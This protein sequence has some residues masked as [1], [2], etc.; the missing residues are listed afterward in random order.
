MKRISA[1]LVFL[2]LLFGLSISSSAQQTA[3]PP[4]KVTPPRVKT[5]TLTGMID[6]VTLAD[7]EKGIRSEI[8]L[9]DKNGKKSIFLVKSVT[10]I[11]DINWKPITLDK[12]TKKQMVRVKYTTTKEGVNEAISIKVTK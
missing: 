8:G 2:I 7:P 9:V 11:Y 4:Y 12:I 10:T 5:K 6:S 3:E 1:V